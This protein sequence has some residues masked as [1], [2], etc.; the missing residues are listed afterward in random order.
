MERFFVRGFPTKYWIDKSGKIVRRHYGGE[1]PEEIERM[2]RS[3][4]Q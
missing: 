2:A 1:P 3:L 4:L